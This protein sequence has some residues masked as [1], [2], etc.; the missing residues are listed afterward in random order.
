M[1]KIKVGVVR[2]DTHAVY[3]ANLIQEH[4]PHVLRELRGNGY[5]YFYT[6]YSD[7][8]K[9][10]FSKVPGFEITKLW[11]EDGKTAENMARIYYD[12]PKVCNTLE[13]V[14]DGVDL[15]LIADCNGDGLD[16]LKL[17]AP[18]I[19][20]G[21][22]TFID[23]PFAYEV[24]DARRMVELAEKHKTPIMSLSILRALPQV[25]RFRNRFAELN[26][27]EFGVIKGSGG[28]MA[29]HVH[30]ISLAQHLF[31]KG[32][33]S[34]EAMGQTPL[35]YVHLDYG[36]KPKRP[37]AGVVL[38]CDSGG[39]PHCAMYASAYSRLGAIH[40]A[41]FDDWIFPDGVIEI[42][43]MIKNMVRTGKPQADY[44]E[45]TEC[46]AIATAARLAQKERRRVYLREV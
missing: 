33:E 20:K 6:C 16:H 37:K 39:S 45:M 31:G 28:A 35:A 27:P 4:D 3:Y 38:A 40:S 34:V 9:M 7:S 26:G 29:A 15:V 46:I 13:E 21:V 17:A 32:V 23:K 10:A 5:F 41:A 8:R 22:P 11:D 36:G 44:E 42:L 25:A 1:S 14:S 18:G 2:C 19:K 30:S 43:K 24:K 12:A